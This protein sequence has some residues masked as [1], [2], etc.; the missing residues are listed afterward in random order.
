[1]ES[2][3]GGGA[4]PRH[5]QRSPSTASSEWASVKEQI[6]QFTAIVAVAA[7]VAF[8]GITLVEWQKRQSLPFCDTTRSDLAESCIPCPDNGRCEGGNLE[9]FSGFIRHGKYCI[10]DRETGK[11]VKAVDDYIV[12][13]VCGQYSLPLC[14]WVGHE[15]LTIIEATQLV[16]KVKL[17]EQLGIDPVKFKVAK[18]QGIRDAEKTLIRSRNFDGL[19]ELQC[20]TDLL[21]YYKPYW[22]RA[23]E[24][25]L[26][27]YSTFLI[28]IPIM[29][30]AV[31]T[32]SR[33]YRKRKVSMRAEQLYT[34]VC[35]TLEEKARDK[36]SGNETWVVASHLRDHLLT[37]RERQNNAAWLIVEQMVGK[38]SRIDQYPKLVKGES[39]VVWEWQVEGV[40]R[41][42]LPKMV[43]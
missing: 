17:D 18:E 27:N 13:Q 34:Q 7:T 29:L 16:E 12:Q 33:V 20:P 30:L 22:C 11:A 1:M 40:L 28:I 32:L 37:L 21:E 5:H 42:P 6:L 14:K 39:K 35:E 36:L 38:D 31:N 23:R 8:L 2:A 25:I 41:S 24:W 26:S 9:C 4:G 15:R 19:L 10:R 43:K 3:Y